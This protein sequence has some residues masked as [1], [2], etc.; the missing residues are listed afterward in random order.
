L[1]GDAR[2]HPRT[3]LLTIV[4]RKRDIWPAISPKNAMRSRLPLDLPS[5]P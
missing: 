2:Q 4:K 5:N 1:A 3:D